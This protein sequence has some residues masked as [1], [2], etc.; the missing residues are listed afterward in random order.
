MV[1]LVGPANM[2][3]ARRLGAA[4]EVHGGNERNL[5]SGAS[6]NLAR[7]WLEESLAKNCWIRIAAL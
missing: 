1:F 4:R 2:C 6:P 3:G 5:P 7:N